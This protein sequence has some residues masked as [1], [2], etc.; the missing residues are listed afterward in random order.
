MKRFYSLLL[1]LVIAYTYGYTQSP[2]SEKLNQLS[3]LIGK[4]ERQNVKP[5]K[6]SHEHWEPVSDNSMRGWGV[7]LAGTDTIFVEKLQIINNEEGL[8]Y[9]ADVAENVEP[10]YF[11]IV[12]L[13]EQGFVCENPEHDFPKRIAYVLSGDQ[14]KATIS[15]DG[16]EIDFLFRKVT[17]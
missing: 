16:K 2:G 5:G 12:A 4:W 15:G 9:V 14:L 10:V 1:L 7:T 6:T 8:F 3:W 11:K 13:S 17:Q